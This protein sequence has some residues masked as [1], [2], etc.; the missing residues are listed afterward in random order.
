MICPLTG[1]AFFGV[2]RPA[3]S[4][5]GQKQTCALQKPMS[6]LLPKATSNATDGMSAKARRLFDHLVGG[7]EQCSQDSTPA[8][9]TV[10]VSDGLDLARIF[11]H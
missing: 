4:A 8:M 7:G 3:M 2:E 1:A 9:E 11:S 5:L 10:E 6:A